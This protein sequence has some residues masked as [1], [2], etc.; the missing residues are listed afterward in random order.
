MCFFARAQQTVGAACLQYEFLL[1]FVYKNMKA[2]SS[3]VR[4]P[5]SSRVRTPS[6]FSHLVLCFV[7]LFFYFFS[8][9]ILLLA[10]IHRRIRLPFELGAY[11]LREVNVIDLEKKKL[12]HDSKIWK[13]SLLHH[14]IIWRLH[15]CFT[16]V[17]FFGASFLGGLHLS[18]ILAPRMYLAFCT[19]HGR[20]AS[21]CLFKSW[22]ALC[23][24]F[25]VSLLGTPFFFWFFC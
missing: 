21:I 15:H 3:W 17:I 16:P 23:P 19:K 8:I 20:A 9:F 4:T 10:S 11:R 12:L 6:F 18:A 25:F 2:P 13:K 24:S 7:S 1:N 22:F 5:A 14:S